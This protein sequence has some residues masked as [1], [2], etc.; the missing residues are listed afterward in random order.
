MRIDIM[1]DLETLGTGV[2]TSIFQI[3]AVM[4]DIVTGK[5]F[6][7]FDEIINIKTIPNLNVSAD[8]LMWWAKTNPLLFA[9]LINNDKRIDYKE[10]L[11]KFYD[12]CVTPVY[13]NDNVYL[14]GNGINFDNVILRQAYVDMGMTYPIRYDCDRDVRT[15]IDLASIKTCK[16]IKEIR[17]MFANSEEHNALQDCIYQASYVSYCYKELMNK[18]I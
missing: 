18:E 14:W 1:L 5:P 16:T 15:I 11:Q 2:H 12:F 10:A 17:S 6:N 9:K 13:G 7:N 4:F 3:S 8:T